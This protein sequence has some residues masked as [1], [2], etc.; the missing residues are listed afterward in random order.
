MAKKIKNDASNF[1]W[2]TS[3]YTTM[4]IDMIIFEDWSGGPIFLLKINGYPS[5]FL[6]FQNRLPKMLIH[7]EQQKRKLIKN[8]GATKLFKR[9]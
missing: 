4:I 8:T 1:R 9:N 7:N 3:D 5:S 2:K 6:S